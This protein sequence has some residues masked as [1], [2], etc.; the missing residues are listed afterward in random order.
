MSGLASRGAACAAAHGDVHPGFMLAAI[1]GL[2]AG[3]YLSG[4]DVGAALDVSVAGLM[5]GMVIGRF[6]RFFGRCCAG[7][8][9]RVAVGAVVLGS[10]TGRCVEFRRNCSRPGWASRVRLR[11]CRWLR[12]LHVP[13]GRRLPFARR[14]VPRQTVHGRMLALILAAALVVVSCTP[15]DVVGSSATALCRYARR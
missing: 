5:L 13:L 3:S 15:V 6:G 4:L 12:S 10:V 11:R 8:L 1:A 14:D 2:V 9:T 7:S